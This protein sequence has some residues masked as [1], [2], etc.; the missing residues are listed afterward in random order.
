[1]QNEQLNEHLSIGNDM[2]NKMLKVAKVEL[3][4]GCKN[5]LNCH[6][7]SY[8]WSDNSFGELLTLLKESLPEGET[9]LDSL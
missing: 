3:Y 9:M 6:L 8:G 5:I 1:M 2:F 7:S 4:H